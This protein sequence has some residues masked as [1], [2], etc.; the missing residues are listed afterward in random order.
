MIK[1]YYAGING[2]YVKYIDHMGDD[3][4]PLEAARMSTGNPTGEDEVKDDKLR[5]YLY[6]NQHMTPFEMSVLQVEVQCPIFVAREWMRHRTMSFNEFSGRYA[7]MPDEYI[8][9][10]PH[11][12]RVQHDTNKQSS[13]GSLSENEAKLAADMIEQAM[14][15][16]NEIYQELIALGVAREQA[17]VILPVGQMTKFRAQANLR[18]WFHF[19]NLRMSS[20]AQLEIRILA[21]AVA[22][23]IKDIWPKTYA[24]F[25]AH[26]LKAE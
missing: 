5:S 17:R 23:I 18:N 12:I 9:F 24:L 25:E 10:A 15:H 20:S 6:R 21:C 16:S 22:E 7:V 26:T 2:E 19:L 11:Q 13:G 1:Y 3:L 8:T 4:M 14:I